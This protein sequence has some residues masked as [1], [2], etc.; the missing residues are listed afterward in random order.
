MSPLALSCLIT[1]LVL[2]GIF[3]GTAFRR[4]LPKHHLSKET[5]DVVRLGHAKTL[6][7]VKMPNRDNYII[8][9]SDRI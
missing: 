1:L 5:Q 8:P 3:I 4:S 6:P 9:Y 7:Q 2:A